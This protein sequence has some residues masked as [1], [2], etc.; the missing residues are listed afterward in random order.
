MSKWRS[1]GKYE[2]TPYDQKADPQ[3]KADEFDEQLADNGGST[4]VF[5]SENPHY[6]WAKEHG[7][8]GH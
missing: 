5:W 2:N 1:S 8:N 6:Q 4:S 3:T 7:T